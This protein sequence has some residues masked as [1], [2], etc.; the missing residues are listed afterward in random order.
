MRVADA[1][2]RSRERQPEGHWGVRGRDGRREGALS[3]VVTS[4]SRQWQ[5]DRLE[6]GHQ[7][8]DSSRHGQSSG[9]RSRRCRPCT[10]SRADR[11]KKRSRQ[12]FRQAMAKPAK[13]PIQ[14]QRL[15]AITLSASQ[16]ALAPN[17]ALGMWLSASPYL[18]SRITFS[19]TAC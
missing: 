11:E 10:T 6:L 14:R 9:S 3:E 12:A 8:H 19:T 17:L 2:N 4:S 7:G 16:A 15:C 18:E 13:R 1:M 5:G